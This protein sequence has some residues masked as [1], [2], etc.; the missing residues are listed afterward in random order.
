MILWHVMLG[1]PELQR[2]RRRR[3]SGRTDEQESSGLFNLPVRTETPRQT[4]LEGGG[5]HLGAVF[6]RT[7]LIRRRIL[8]ITRLRLISFTSLSMAVRG[9]FFALRRRR[10]AAPPC[11]VPP[12]F[13]GL[14]LRMDSGPRRSP[15]LSRSSSNL[16]QL[17]FSRASTRPWPFFLFLFFIFFNFLHATAEIHYIY[18]VID[19]TAMHKYT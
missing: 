7:I 14:C 8:T 17:N 18:L 19:C 15:G 1:Y 6:R 3:R 11:R 13:H 4:F 12:C 9:Q 10:Q 2:L 5:V 16:S